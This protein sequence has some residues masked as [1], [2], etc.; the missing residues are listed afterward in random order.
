MRM[1]RALGVEVHVALPPDGPLAAECAAAGVVVHRAAIDF[2]ARRPWAFAAVARQIRALVDG[3][4]PDLIHSHFVGTTVSMRLALGREHPTPRVFQVP[5]PLHL[6]HVFFRRA[7]LLAAGAHDYW[8]GSCRWT[9]DRYGR[10][11]VTADRRFLSYYGTDLATYTTA[12]RG[13]LRAELS[14]PARTR[15]VGM[16]AYMY[17]PRAVLGQW[18]GLKGHEDLIDAVA[19]CVEQG[20]DVVAVFIGG[21]WKGASRYERRVREYGRRRLGARAVFLGTRLDVP[22]L[23]PDIDIAVHPSHSENVGGAAESLLMGV[24]TIATAIGG[25]PDVIRHGETGWLVPPR[26][27]S[28]L[29]DAIGEALDDPV[30][31]RRMALEGQRR[32]RQMLDVRESARQVKAIYETILSRP[33]VR[34]GSRLEPVRL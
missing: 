18:R 32:A 16:V 26:R 12:A 34:T 2:P 5:G 20:R 3:V 8:I 29:A 9:V 15:I 10:C 23:Y 21:A 31:A 22:R 14:L 30:R 11:G 4:E 24:P 17:A 6:E 7:E 33:G 19:L 28:A 13:A 27:P 1:L 25:F